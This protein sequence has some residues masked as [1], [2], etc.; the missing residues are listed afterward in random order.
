MTWS[1]IGSA[2]QDG[3]R[4]LIYSPHS[5]RVVQEVGWAYDYKGAPGYWMTPAGPNGRGYI[6]LP[7]APTHWMH[8]P[9]A[10][11]SAT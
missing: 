5:R 1:D 3:T 7:E 2:P 4:I 9:L 11:E 6:I 8:L 10:P